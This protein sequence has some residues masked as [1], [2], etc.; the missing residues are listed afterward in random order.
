[1]RTL[2]AWPR[3]VSLDGLAIVALAAV[4]VLVAVGAIVAVAAVFRREVFDEAVVGELRNAPA[5][6]RSG[7]VSA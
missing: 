2:S 6:Q 1:M 3:S 4:G 5:A 7:R